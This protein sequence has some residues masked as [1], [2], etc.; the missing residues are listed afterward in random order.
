MIVTGLVGSLVVSSY[1]WGYWLF[2]TVALFYV[3]VT[4]VSGLSRR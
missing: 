3:S 2:G 1:K 4:L